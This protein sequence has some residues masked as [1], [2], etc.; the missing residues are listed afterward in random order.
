[1]EVFSKR[2]FMEF[3]QSEFLKSDN[4]DV[5]IV[6]PVYNEAPN[7]EPLMIEIEA[8][9]SRTSLRFEA[10][11]VDDAS[12]DSTG[13]LVDKLAEDYPWVR[14]LHHRRN[15]G[16]SAAQASGFAAASGNVVVTIDGDGQND[17]RDIPRLLKALEAG[18][19]CVAGVRRQ[20]RDN[21]ARRVSSKI[22]NRFRDF[23]TGDRMSDAGCTMRAV[24]YSCLAEV[25]RFNGMHRFLPTLLRAQGYVVVERFVEHRPRTAGKSKYGVWNRLWRGVLDCLAVRWYLKRAFPGDRMANAVDRNGEFERVSAA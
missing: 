18:V 25:P 19:H 17:P 5:S 16:Q 13:V 8:A 1:M 12:D 15:C 2:V 24:R 4:P 3:A 21:W 10:I 22:G 20:R 23:V 14:A 9:F 6:I 7:I 11:W